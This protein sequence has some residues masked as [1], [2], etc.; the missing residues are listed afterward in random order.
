MRSFL[1]LVLTLCMALLHAQWKLTTPIKTLSEIEDI[2]MISDDLGFAIDRPN[3]SILRTFDGGITWDRRIS[4]LTDNPQAL[5]AWD[6]QRVIVVGESGSLYRSNDGLTTI[7]GGEVSEVA[8][9]LNCVFFVND[10]LGWVGTQSGKIYRSTDGGDSWTQMQSGLST[11][12]YVT[13]I[14]F[15]DTHTGYASCYGGAMMLKSTDGGLTW[16]SVQPA[17]QIVLMRALHFYDTQLGVAVGSAG[18]VIRTTDGGATWDSIPTNSTYSMEDMAVQGDVIVACGW[19]GRVLRSTDRGLTWTEQ[20]LVNEHYSV[21]LTPSGRGMIGSTGRIFGTDD[22]GETWTLLHR[23]TVGATMNKMSFADADTGVVAAWTQTGAIESGMVRTTDGGRTWK[24]SPGGGGLGV[25]IRADGV[26]CR[27]GGSGSFSRTNDQFAT[28][29][30]GTGPSVAIRCVWSLNAT[31]HIVAGGYVNGGIYRTTNNGTSWT[32]VYDQGNVY[33][34]FFVNDQLGFAVGEGGFSART[35]DGGITWA[36][37]NETM[38]NDQFSVFFFNAELGWMVGATCGAR[39]TDG[40]DSWEPMC[41][42]PSYSKSVFFTSADTGYVVGQSGQTLRST[43]GG[44]TWENVL[45]EILNFTAGD[46]AWVDGAI[47]MG[48]TSGDIYRAEVACPTTAF[49]PTTYEADGLLCTNTGG[50]AQW[51]FNDEPIPDGDTP[52][53]NPELVGNYHVIMTN[54][55]GCVSQPSTTV[56]VINTGMVPTGPTTTATLFPNPA[57]RSVVIVRSVDTTGELTIMDAQGRVALTERISGKSTVL[58]LS[59]LKPGL[60]LVRIAWGSDAETL[61]LV[62][63]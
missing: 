4:G 24:A 43:D 22:M 58:D 63:E 38:G 62:K 40:G 18:E 20:S 61:R 10:T 51:Y 11:T 8:G 28:S 49:T 2:T 19:W 1:T 41:A 12:N 59:A 53:I 35:M 60:Y 55:L 44:E 34:L 5:F 36:P 48:G 6:A 23:G 31:T 25:H 15:V 52:C 16:Q 17:G 39:T 7:T 42:I 46:A 32:Y 13:A 3:G 14:Q 29:I 27:G 26:G 33:D 37:M 45:P 47:V 54:E 57:D 30:P 21:A 56:Q 9:H 50:A